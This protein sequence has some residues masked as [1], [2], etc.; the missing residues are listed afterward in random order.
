MRHRDGC[1][2]PVLACAFFTHG[3]DY[4]VGYAALKP[5]RATDS[6]HMIANLEGAII[7]KLEVG[8]IFPRN[9]QNR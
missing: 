6:Y 1:L 4:S 8:E 9:L 3:A 2:Y 7:T 5:E